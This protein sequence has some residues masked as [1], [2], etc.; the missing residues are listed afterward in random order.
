M[1]NIT[2]PCVQGQRSKFQDSAQHFNCTSLNLLVEGRESIRPMIIMYNFIMK[3]GEQKV[4]FNFKVK[5]QCHS[6]NVLKSINCLTISR[7]IVTLLSLICTPTLLTS[8]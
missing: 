7:I 6:A 1:G 3:H 5:C 2:L 8:E 4:T